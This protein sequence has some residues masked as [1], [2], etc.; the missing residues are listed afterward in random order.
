MCAGGEP[1]AT[2]FSYLFLA[3]FTILLSTS[4]SCAA[5]ERL[6]VM[7]TCAPPHVPRDVFLGERRLDP[8]GQLLEACQVA[9]DS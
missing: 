8:V 2:H 6:P 5:M 9:L 4:F 3:E 1:E 7:M